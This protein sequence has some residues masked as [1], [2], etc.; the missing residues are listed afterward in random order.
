LSP[1]RAHDYTPDAIG[2]EAGCRCCTRSLGHPD[3]IA[4]R[5]RGTTE[6]AG[7][8]VVSNTISYRI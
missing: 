3:S 4:G 2:R 7:A 5:Q 8:K 6:Q 1:A